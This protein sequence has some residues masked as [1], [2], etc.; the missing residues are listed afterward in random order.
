M[1]IP[2]THYRVLVADPAQRELEVTCTVAEPAP[3]G[4]A[5]WLP[6][7]TPGSYLVREFARHFVAV[8]A[9]CRGVPVA[10]A[11]TSKN[12]WLAAPCDGPLQVS[13]RIHAYDLSV[14]TAYVDQTRAY[15]NGSSV[16]LC[17]EGAEEGAF[18]VEIASVPG[19]PH[20]R[21]ATTLEPAGAPLWGF[22]TYR[23]QGYDELIDHPVEIAAFDHVSF[24]AG[25]VPHDIVVT[26]RH[27]GDLDRLAADVRRVC[28]WQVELFG[29]EPSPRAPFDRYLFQ[30]MVV[31]EGYGGLEHRNSTSLL[32]SR[33]ELPRRGEAGIGEA[34]RRLLGLFS[35]EYFHAWNV[36]R[37]KPEAFSP[38]DLGGESYTRQLW[39]FEGFTSYYDDLALRRSGVIDTRSY[40]ELVGQA[41]TGVLRVPGRHL[42][43]VAD[44][45][46]DAWIKFYRPDE[47]TPN[48]VVSYYAKGA[49]VALAL[50]LTLRLAGSSLD[51]LVRRLWRQYGQ[52][53]K[54]VPEDGIRKLAVEL[55]GSRMEEI[56]TRYVDG[57]DDIPFD[58]LLRSFGVRYMVRASEGANDRG[59]KP[60]GPEAH[61][62]PRSSFGVKLGSGSELRLQH[63]FSGGAAAR[64]GLAPGDVIVAI[65]GLRATRETFDAL[66]KRH[67]PGETIPLHAF[68]RDELLSF[69]VNLDAAAADTC[70]LELDQGAGAEALERRRTWLGDDVPRPA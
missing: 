28:Q 59:G 42:Q 49:L 69:E 34:Y 11:K 39:A 4:Q 67:A 1:P 58:G 33:S 60:G 46:F 63:V 37:I 6:V 52:T 45:S 5:F 44:S 50:D 62:R 70:W 15:F 36:K 32:A 21:V 18:E 41:I 65:E 51:E 3:E 47:N 9:R 17:P 55:G 53:G 31:G 24:Q 27:R 54:G 12:R 56:F 66:A 25:G 40:L 64:A 68:R 35:H 23:A 22:G 26:G 7:W 48:A 2:L 57:I 16:F 30:L 14:R 20:W 8:T 38:C 10:I 61:Q 19:H 13:A 43:S 29:G